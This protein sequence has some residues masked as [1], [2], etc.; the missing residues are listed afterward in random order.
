MGRDFV[1]FGDVG[2]FV[3][4]TALETDFGALFF[5]TLSSFS[6]VVLDTVDDGFVSVGWSGFAT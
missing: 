2:P 4:E 6:L 5:E 1:S 3:A